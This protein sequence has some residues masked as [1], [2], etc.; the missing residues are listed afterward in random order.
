MKTA[1]LSNALREC[2][3]TTN[4]LVKTLDEEAEL[5][6]QSSNSNKLLVLIKEN[7][8]VLNSAAYTGHTK[9]LQSI[10]R[11]PWSSVEMRCKA[12]HQH[13]CMWQR[14]NGEWNQYG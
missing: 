11:P 3:A 12:V 2:Q 7:N 5:F 14:H 10:L 4:I 9:L 8:S 6:Y 1:K 13:L